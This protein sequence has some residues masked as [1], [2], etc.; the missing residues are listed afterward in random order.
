MIF[1]KSFKLDDFSKIKYRWISRVNLSEKLGKAAAL[2]ALPLITALGRQTFFFLYFQ[3]LNAI[4]LTAFW[5]ALLYLAMKFAILGGKSVTCFLLRAMLS[6]HIQNF[7]CGYSCRRWCRDGKPKRIPCTS[8]A[9]PTA[10][11]WF[12]HYLR[13]KIPS[14]MKVYICRFVCKKCYSNGKIAVCQDTLK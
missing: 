1:E 3:V 8:E 7:L 14:W 12:T 9:L 2:P 4:I 13:K 6:E 11:G 5:F 10:K